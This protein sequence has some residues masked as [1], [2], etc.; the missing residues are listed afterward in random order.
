MIMI[1][2]LHLWHLADAVIQSDL[3]CDHFTQVGEGRVRSLA[4]GLLLV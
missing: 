1:N 3:Q 2:H 4:Q